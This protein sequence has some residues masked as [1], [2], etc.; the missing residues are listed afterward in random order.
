MNK[1]I[2]WDLGDVLLKYI[3]PEDIET[4]SNDYL[5]CYVTDS[6]LHII[7]DL[8]YSTDYII[9]GYEGCNNSGDIISISEKG[10]Y[11]TS[12]YEGTHEVDIFVT[13]KCNSNCIMCPLSEYVRKQTKNGYIAWLKNYIKLLPENISYLNV[14]GGEPTLAGRDFLDVMKLLSDKYNHSDFQLLTNG[15]SVADKELLEDILSVS[16]YGIRFAIPIHSTNEDVHDGITRV[17]YSFKQTDVGIKNLLKRNQKVE[18][19]IV[20]S[21]KNIETIFESAK[22]IQKNYKGVFCVNFV[23]M[24]MMGNAAV[25]KDELWIDYSEAFV[26]I[27]KAIDLLVCSGIDVQLYNFPLCAVDKGYWH[28][29]SKSITDYK[30]RF[31]DECDECQVKDICGGFF[32]STKQLMQ[33]KVQPVRN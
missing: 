17:P 21:K 4:D 23:A 24:E 26:K 10:V 11:S 1:V 20:I 5:K 2:N 16:P 31:M 7:G 19:R 27:R 8:N 13:N 15:R 30:I 9:E 25:N 33:P 28:I 3:D 29:A 6:K 18:V 22:Y 12:Y 14:T 32:Y